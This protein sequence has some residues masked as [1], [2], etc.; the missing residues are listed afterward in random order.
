M[1][2]KWRLKPPTLSKNQLV[3]VST[4][5][6]V[7]YCSQAENARGG[8]NAKTSWCWPFAEFV[9]K[10]SI[11]MDLSIK[12]FVL[13]GSVV[14]TGLSAGLFYAWSVSVIP[15]TQRVADVT[16]LQTMQ[17][18]NKA[19]LNPAFYLIFFGSIVFLSIASIYEIH[20]RSLTFWLLLFSSILYL[21]GTIGVTGLGNVPLNNQLD[22]LT[23][24]E[25]QKDKIEE[26]RKLYE[27][28]WNR[29]HMVRTVF[30]VVSFILTVLALFT[31]SK[32]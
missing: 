31:S 10:K 20:T 7:N 16:Y 6:I 32:N 5:T 18:I 1:S 29:L 13:F 9:D 21:V 25:M 4:V 12:S 2:S 24:A 17:S 3:K 22:I 23:L 11:T 8:F 26:F 27:V 14:L 30:A 28:N 19:I 15:G